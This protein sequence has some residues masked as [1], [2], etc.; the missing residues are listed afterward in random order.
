MADE[1]LAAY[2]REN[3]AAGHSKSAIR[4]Q[5]LAS[6]W[7]SDAVDVA[8]ATARRSA[9][10]AS[11]TA[12]SGELRRG[13]RTKM[14]RWTHRWPVRLAVLI[15]I[16]VGGGGLIVHAMV[17]SH[18][19]ALPAQSVRHLT[20]TQM[21][22][23][24]VTTIAGA[25]GQYAA[26]YGVLPATAV[27]SN[28]SLVL[29]DTVCNPTMAQTAALMF[30]APSQVKIRPYHSQLAAPSTTVIYLVPQAKCANGAVGAPNTNPRSMV[31]LYEAATSPQPTARCIV[32]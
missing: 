11:N 1:A 29:C 30:Y 23:N 26:A 7:R 10:T 21:Q 8:L 24:D 14:V 28:G 17:G 9:S 27:S 2:I 31:L 32:L 15:L 18:P 19:A 4:E 5:L 25:V 16:A 3:L 6:G 22:A 13:S 20:T 12:S